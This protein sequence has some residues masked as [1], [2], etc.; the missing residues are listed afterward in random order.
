MG[1]DVYGEIYYGVPI[2]E[3]PWNEQLD[4][5]GH[6]DPETEELWFE[7]EPEG[8]HLL[9]LG[10]YDTSEFLLGF[11]VLSSYWGEPVEID[12]TTL[13]IETV[14]KWNQ[15][16]KE[17]LEFLKLPLTEPKFYLSALYSY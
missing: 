7:M 9:Y 3:L 4:I 13:D 5:P 15:S 2:G 10:S 14:T 1:V 16:I 17:R 6:I 8:A 11:H 12:T